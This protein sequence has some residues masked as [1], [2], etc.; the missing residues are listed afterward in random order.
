MAD[1]YPDTTPE[2]RRNRRLRLA[3]ARCQKRKI[4]CDGQY[5]TCNNCKKASA[6][7]TDGGSLRLRD[8]PPEHEV[9]TGLRKR[10]AVLEAA[11]R[12]RDSNDAVAQPPFIAAPANAVT[13]S[14]AAALSGLASSAPWHGNDSALS[15]EIGLISVGN[16]TAPRYIGPSSGYFLAKLLGSS[17]ASRRTKE[18]GGITDREVHGLVSRHLLPLEPPNSLYGPKCLPGQKQAKQICDAYFDV[19]GWQYPILNKPS[20]MHMLDRLYAKN[21]GAES[22]DD[23]TL[24]QVYMVLAMGATVLSHRLRVPLSGDQYCLAAFEHFQQLNLENSLS[25]LQCLLLVLIFTMHNPHVKLNPWYL[26]YQCIAATLDLG[27]QRNI[28]AGMGM[29]L[30][31]QEM[32]TRIFWVVFAIDRTIATIMGRPIGLRDEACELRYPQ[33][34]D[35]DTLFGSSRGSALPALEALS[36]SKL[37]SMAFSLH[38]FKLARLNSEI[39]YVANSIVRDTPRHA[40]PPP[41]DIHQWQTEMAGQLEAWV[42]DIPDGGDERGYMRI[43]CEIRYHSM[44]QLLLR[45]SPAISSPTLTAFEKCYTSCQSCITLFNQLYRDDLLIY[46]W[47]VFHSLLLSIVTMLYTVRAAPSIARRTDSEQF[48]SDIYMGMNIL[49]AVGEHWPGARRSLNVLDELV[50]DAVRW[51]KEVRQQ[52]NAELYCGSDRG[53][54]GRQDPQ[55]TS[56]VYAS[57]SSSTF[58]DIEL[59]QNDHTAAISGVALSSQRIPDTIFCS[60]LQEDTTTGGFEEDWWMNTFAGQLGVL[61]A[62]NIDSLMHSFFADTSPGMGSL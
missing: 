41:A 56:R 17:H 22:Q 35:D 3:C 10:I 4:R 23:I 51:I 20:F 9:V 62:G 37:S 29:S 12:E 27:L 5:P 46:S 15:H 11:L 32:R 45:P 59:Q 43:F 53:M 19:I 34:I 8:V 28:T 57:E 61:D 39:K 48:M 16:S 13:P 47:T 58:A 2:S 42:R 40:Y 25:G 36:D 24:F 44:M 38:L 31:E 55:F 60:T 7:C 33:L 14:P 49:S 1:E 21:V 26:N 54:R 18:V 6:A 52:Q 50:R 30:M